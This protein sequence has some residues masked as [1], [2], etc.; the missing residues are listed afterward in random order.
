MAQPT[1]SISTPSGSTAIPCTA[2]G[3]AAPSPGKTLVAMGYQINSGP[4]HPI[5]NFTSGGGPWNFQLT[6]S[7]CP[8]IGANYLLTVYAGQDSGDFGTDAVNFTRSS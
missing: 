3:T 2:S 1:V 5:N 8:V 6:Q 4:I 7:D